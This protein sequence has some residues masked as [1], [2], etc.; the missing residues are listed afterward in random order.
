MDYS[1]GVVG[2]NDGLGSD[3]LPQCSLSF[4]SQRQRT[5]HVV[6]REEKVGREMELTTGSLIDLGTHPHAY[7]H[8][9]I[10]FLTPLTYYNLVFRG[11]VNI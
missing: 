3:L 2:S 4:E 7:F 6:V 8:Y 10:L 5:R 1:W 11:G 9:S